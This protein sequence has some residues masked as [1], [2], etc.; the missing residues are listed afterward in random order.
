[1]SLL[2]DLRCGPLVRRADG[3]WWYDSTPLGTEGAPRLT[4]DALGNRLS[5]VCVRLSLALGRAAQ[6]LQNVGHP[7]MESEQ[8]LARY[9][10]WHATGAWPELVQEIKP[11]FR[12]AECRELLRSG[13]TLLERMLARLEDSDALGLVTDMEDWI[14]RASMQLEEEPTP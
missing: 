9:Q 14:E 8:V 12:E 11:A 3:T 2:K 5:L 1:M 13:M 4:C 7:H 10:H 6:Q